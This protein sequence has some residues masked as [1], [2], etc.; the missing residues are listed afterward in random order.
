MYKDASQRGPCSRPLERDRPLHAD[1]H[2]LQLRIEYIE[3][4]YETAVPIGTQAQR[5]PGF[6]AACCQS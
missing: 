6:R 4:T 5:V 2:S 3:G 1:L